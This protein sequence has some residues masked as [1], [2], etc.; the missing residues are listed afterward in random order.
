MSA[1]EEHCENCRHLQGKIA[2]LKA[3][4]VVAKAEIRDKLEQLV[5]QGA[6]ITPLLDR[7][8]EDGYDVESLLFG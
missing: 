7:M 2:V 5:A 4:D 3:E 6:D 1:A 8:A